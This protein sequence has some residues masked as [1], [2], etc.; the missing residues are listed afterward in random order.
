VWGA[1][2]LAGVPAFDRSDP[3]VAHTVNI[4][5]RRRRTMPFVQ[6]MRDG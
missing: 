1:V 2:L 3:G 6:P 4:L 5:N